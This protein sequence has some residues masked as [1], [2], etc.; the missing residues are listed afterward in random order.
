[1]PRSYLLVEAP[2][3]QDLN[4]VNRDGSEA[5]AQNQQL[6]KHPKAV[7]FAN[8][9]SF[10][11]PL[12]SI[13]DT[14]EKFKSLE[15]VIKLKLNPNDANVYDA[16]WIAALTEN[17]SQNMTFV[18]LKDKFNWKLRSLED[19]RKCRYKELCMGKNK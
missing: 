15:N 2:S 14:D 16:V 6:L 4:K 8:G 18:K 10:T 13:N 7:E 19:K 11:S 5:T 17:V 9:T 12:M 3:H 1:M